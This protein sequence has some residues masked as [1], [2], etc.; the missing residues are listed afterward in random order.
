M[1]EVRSEPCG[2]LGK[3]MLKGPLSPRPGSELQS[4]Y[5][6]SQS[7]TSGRPLLKAE[8]RSLRDLNQPASAYKARLSGAWLA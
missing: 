6:D 4:G 1:S 5:L 2:Y 8:V 3:H 7:G